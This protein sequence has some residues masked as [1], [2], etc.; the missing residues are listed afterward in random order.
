VREPFETL[1][2]LLLPEE[3]GAALHAGPAWRLGELP[4]TPSMVWGREPWPAGTP[5]PRAARAA[6]ARERALLS[7]RLRP[8]T[9]LSLGAVHRWPP[10]GHRRSVAADLT[11]AAVL[12]GAVVELVRG[13]VRRV[14]DL[15][16]QAAHVAGPPRDI[17]PVSAGAV[18]ARVMAVGEP[19]VLRGTHRQGPGDPLRAAEAL[20]R[21]AGNAWPF[22]P[23]PIGSGDVGEA[24]WAVES[25]LAGHRPSRLTRSLLLELRSFCAN[26]P[27][28]EAPPRIGPDF[29]ALA[30]AFP[31]WGGRLSRLR[32]RLDEQVARLPPIM[33]HGDLWSG[34]LLVTRDRLT[35]LIDWDSWVPSG[36]PGTD[37]LHAYGTELAGRSGRQL[38]AVWLMRPWR[39]STFTSWTKPYWSALGAKPDP[40]LLD[41]VGAAWW[42]SRVSYRLRLRPLLSEDRRWVNDTVEGVLDALEP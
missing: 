4:G 12:G 33:C 25:E 18:I 22:L 10:P 11:R 23:R 21:L 1:S 28:G 26:L 24:V 3:G 19:A 31:H 29:E 42:A 41:A 17:R 38:G 32:D 27:R 39:S 13:P 2:F 40:E 36:V 34:N 8:P 5:I 20:K 37:L 15:C 7:L 30:S 6:V 9:G 35:G 14:I 16:A